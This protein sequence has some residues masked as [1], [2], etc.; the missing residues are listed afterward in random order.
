MWFIIIIMKTKLTQGVKLKIKKT[1]WIIF[2]L[3]LIPLLIFQI[4][5]IY[6]DIFHENNINVKEIGVFILIFELLLASISAYYE[7]G[8]FPLRYLLIFSIS[9]LIFYLA[10]NKSFLEWYEILTYIVSIILLSFTYVSI[11]I[12]NKIYTLAE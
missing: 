3:F 1:L 8:H 11:K 12:L 6:M 9:A 7:N 5:V 2:G 10:L 4:E